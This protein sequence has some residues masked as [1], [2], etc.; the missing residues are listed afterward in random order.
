MAN[1]AFSAER[2]R[3][4]L[5]VAMDQKNA[6]MRG[7]TH[8]L[9]NPLGAARGHIDLMLD[10]IINPAD[11]RGALERVRSLVTSVS[12]SVAALLDVARSES[13]EMRLARAA[14]DLCALVRAAIEDHRSLAVRKEQTLTIEDTGDCRA[15]AD[16]GRVRHIV[17]NLLSNSIKYTPSGGRI[18]VIVSRRERDGRAWSAVVVEDSGPGIPAESR[19][20]VFQEFTRLPGTRDVTAG[21]G[22]GLTVSRRV[23]RMMGGDVTLD[24]GRSQPGDHPPLG[25]ATFTL[26]LPPAEETKR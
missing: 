2:D 7:I 9:Q 16:A 19:E 23:A 21:S 22:I 1:I 20:R 25:G 24:D 11:W 18:R 10:G 15:E 17:D 12:E 6:F 5:A 13:G 14:V 3:R 4:A 26:W 8:D